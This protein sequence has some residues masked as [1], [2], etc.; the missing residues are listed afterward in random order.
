MFKEDLVELRRS[1]LSKMSGKQDESNLRP[2]DVCSLLDSAKRD[3]LIACQS[4]DQNAPDA[5]NTVMNLNKVFVDNIVIKKIVIGVNVRLRGVERILKKR[6]P[7]GFLLNIGSNFGDIS[8]AEFMFN[9]L[10]L[11]GLNETEET[12]SG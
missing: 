3:N 11:A 2:Q 12:I 6:G 7:M 5:A 9:E 8:G 4:G 10:E 1:V